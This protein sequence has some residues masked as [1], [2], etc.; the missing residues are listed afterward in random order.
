[1]TKFQF[2]S[3]LYYRPLR[4]MYGLETFYESTISWHIITNHKLLFMR[5]PRIY[6]SLPYQPVSPKCTMTK[7]DN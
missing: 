3:T 1:M 4:L 7:W 5:L 6:S 2:Y